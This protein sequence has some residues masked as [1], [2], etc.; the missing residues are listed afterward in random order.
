M[1]NNAAID[2][3]TGNEIYLRDN[4]GNITAGA[5]GGSGVSFWAGASEPSNAPFVVNADG[6]IKATSGT[7]S[8]FIQMPYYPISSIYSKSGGVYTV[9]NRYSYIVIDQ[10]GSAA[11]TVR[12]P[13]PSAAYNGFVYHFINVPGNTERDRYAVDV[14]STSNANVIVRFTDFMGKSVWPGAAAKVNLGAGAYDFLC[15]K[16]TASG[17]YMWLITNATGS[18]VGFSYSGGTYTSLNW[19]NTVRSVTI[20]QI[21]VGPHGS[22]NNILYVEE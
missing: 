3:L 2:F 4:N 9:D 12:L 1:A 16:L 21:L 13:A 14:V 20:D 11:S 17:S 18:A 22:A 10:D 7:F 6:S 19:V 8:G 5:A 15:V